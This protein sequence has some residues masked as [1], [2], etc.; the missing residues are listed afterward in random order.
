MAVQEAWC[1]CKCDAWCL[2]LCTIHNF[3]PYNAHAGSAGS[4][5]SGNPIVVDGAQ[6]LY[7]KPGVPVDVVLKASRGE[8]T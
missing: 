3:K 5:V 6:W 4:Y 2:T 7:K 8:S 1:A